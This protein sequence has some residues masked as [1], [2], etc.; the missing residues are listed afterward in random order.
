MAAAWLLPTH[1][2]RMLFLICGAAVVIAIVYV[3][4]RVP[5]SE[6]WRQQRSGAPSLRASAG[7]GRLAELFA[8][9]MLRVTLLGTATSALALSAYWGASTWLPTFLVRERGLDV[10]TMARF[11]AVLNLGMFLGYNVFGMLADRIGKQRAVIASL[12]GSGLTLPV[13]AVVSD[14][15]TLLVLGPLFAFFMAFAGLVGSYFAELFPTRIRATGAGFC[16]NVGRGISAFA[17]LALGSAATS[18]GFAPG[19]ALCGGLFLLSA[20]VVALLPR[21]AA[22]HEAGTDAPKAPGA[23]PSLDAG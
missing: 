22:S 10:A 3:W 16:F 21:T 9:G 1:G 4:L 19:I 20:I 15:A 17:P 14:H 18:Y 7:G 12:V 11:L 2:W 8:P 5:E 23:A 13:Y 6:V